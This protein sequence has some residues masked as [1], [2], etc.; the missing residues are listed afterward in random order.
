M[1]VSASV[2]PRSPERG[3]AW[4]R[5]RGLIGINLSGGRA[6][7]VVTLTVADSQEE[8][9]KVTVFSVRVELIDVKV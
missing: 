4:L 7:L 9:L 3:A 5:L 2:K 1:A 8:L 6:Y